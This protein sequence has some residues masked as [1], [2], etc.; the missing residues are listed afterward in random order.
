MNPTITSSI[1]VGT[2]KGVQILVVD[3]DI[4]SGVLLTIFLSYFGANVTTSAS[5][6]EAVNSLTCFFPH[7][8]ICEIR[9]LGENVYVLL[10]KL[11]EIESFSKNHI[12]IIVTSTCVNGTTEEIPEIEFAGYLL[13]PIDLDKLLVMIEHLLPLG[14]NNL[15]VEPL[16]HSFINS[17]AVADSLLTEIKE[18]NE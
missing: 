5:I 13:K 11:A 15:L 12:P 16:Q 9:F 18:N 6:K 14:G 3:N 17:L 7:I 2:L 8:I 4:D 10:N 1:K